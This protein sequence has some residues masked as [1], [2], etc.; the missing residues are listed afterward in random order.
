MECGFSG[1]AND[2]QGGLGVPERSRSGRGGKGGL[3]G[4]LSGRSERSERSG[5]FFYN[6]GPGGNE[7]SGRLMDR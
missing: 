3:G 5:R 4:F 7:R 6:G 1:E 2:I